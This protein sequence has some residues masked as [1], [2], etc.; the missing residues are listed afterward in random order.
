MLGGKDKNSLLETVVFRPLYMQKWFG[1]PKAI[2][3][4]GSFYFYFLISEI[5]LYMV[6]L[7]SS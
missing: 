4:S 3:D 7:I 6:D 1:C 2:S 5:I